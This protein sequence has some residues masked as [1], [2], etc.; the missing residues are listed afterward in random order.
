MA[1]CLWIALVALIRVIRYVFLMMLEYG[2][3]FSI[4]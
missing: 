1:K 3:S 4:R 2:L